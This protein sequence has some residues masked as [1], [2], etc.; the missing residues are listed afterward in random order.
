MLNPRAIARLTFGEVRFREELTGDG[1]FFEITV[2]ASIKTEVRCLSSH[3]FDLFKH[4][5]LEVVYSNT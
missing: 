1:C 5:L 3:Y 4:I 2:N